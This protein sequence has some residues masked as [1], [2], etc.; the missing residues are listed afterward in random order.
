MFIKHEGENKG[1][2][3]ISFKETNRST[4]YKSE[5]KVVETEALQYLISSDNLKDVYGIYS[6]AQGKT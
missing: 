2:S 5:C 6:A 1:W 4:N 3:I